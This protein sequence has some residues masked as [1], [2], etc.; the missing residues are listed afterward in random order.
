M[1]AT[2][3]RPVF[4]NYLQMRQPLPMRAWY[5]LRAGSIAISAALIVVLLV[6]PS[7]GLT[8]WW[9]FV[10]PFLPLWFFLAPGL[11]RN[12]C[13]MAALNQLP[14]LRGFSR[15]VTAPAWLRNYSYVIGF[16]LFMALAASRK[17]E[18]NTSGWAT[19]LLLFAALLAAFAGGLVFKGKSG[20]CSSICPLLPVQR[21]YGQTPFVVLPNAHCQPCVGCAKN[22]YD[23]NPHVAWLADMHDDDQYFAGYR[24]FFAGALPGF[25]LG[26]YRVPN[27]P[28]ISV[29]E[30]YARLLLYVLAS[31]GVFIV[32][33]W[34]LKLDTA[35]LTVAFGAAALNIYYWFNTTNLAHQIQKSFGVTVPDSAV[36]ASRAVVLALSALW[37][38]RTFRKD[39]RYLAE[40]GGAPVATLAPAGVAAARRQSGSGQP[41]VTIMPEGRRIAAQ[42]GRTLLDLVEAAGCQIEAGCRMGMCGADPVA[43]VEGMEQLSPVRQDEQSTLQR[44]G[45]ATNTRLACVA[46][47]QGSVVVK[48]KADPAV[49]ADASRLRSFSFDRS[50]KNVVVIGNGIAGTTAAD[51]V[52]RRH[53]ECSITVI[54][55]EPH[56]L[57]NRM[58][59]ERLIYGRSAMQGLYLLP[60]SWYQEHDVTSILNTRVTAISRLSKEIVLG[61]NERLPY[62]RLI[63]AMGSRSTVPSIEGF[64][65][66][67]TFVLREAGDAM[68]VRSRVL[69]R[70]KSSMLPP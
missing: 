5:V 23:F 27:P 7:L 3:P 38:W 21:V 31:V 10:I 58:A 55:R 59:I 25:I 18:F 35:K 11:W 47:V 65:Q 42:A 62:D 41:E 69:T 45:L 64:G 39:N 9:G 49:A 44:L 30:L 15:G 29:P 32:L 17:A 28:A 34:L 4:P 33:S 67:G 63:L 12:V 2:P 61:T 8:I 1:T 48:L 16:V 22:C 26:F 36:W 37:L 20:W 66:P 24:R 46:K 13:P 40:V 68:A 56:L 19:A 52:R 54:G 14:R 43:I 6:R 57:Y 60:E 70:R 51:H 53:P 50:V